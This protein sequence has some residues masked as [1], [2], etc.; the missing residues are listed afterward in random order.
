[1]PENK[2]M[3]HPNPAY[4][5]AKNSGWRN[6]YWLLS[7]EVDD[8]DVIQGLELPTYEREASMFQRP[9]GLRLCRHRSFC[10]RIIG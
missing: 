1:M 4:S 7:I 5:L 8:E 10:D 6:A 9:Y 3:F 2:D